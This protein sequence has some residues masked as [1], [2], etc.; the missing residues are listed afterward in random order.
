VLTVKLVIDTRDAEVW[1]DGQATSSRAPVEE[2]LFLE[3]GKHTIE[4]RLG[5]RRRATGSIE[6][7]AGTT[8][9]LR[10]AIPAEEPVP[11]SAVGPAVAFSAGGAGLLVGAITGAVSIAKFGDFEKACGPRLECPSSLRGE[12]ET[13]RTLGHVSTAGFVLA[14]VGA[15]L[16]VTLLLWPSSPKSVARAGVELGPGFLSVKGA[17]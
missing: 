15:A 13:G 2:P 17:F 8:R 6:G 10:L 16:G 11:R 7:A 1:V 4:A 5:P 3:P 14:G 12:V 9:E